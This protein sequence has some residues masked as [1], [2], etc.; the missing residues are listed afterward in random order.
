M[1]EREAL[2]DAVDILG[3]PGEGDSKV[4]SYEY[5]LAREVFKLRLVLPAGSEHYRSGWDDALE[6]AVELLRGIGEPGAVRRLGLG[7]LEG[8]TQ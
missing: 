1:R 5:R 2:T 7:E 4:R 8:E 6:A 3:R